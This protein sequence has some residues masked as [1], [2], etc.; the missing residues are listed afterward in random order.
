MTP[1][2][3]IKRKVKEVL[4]EFGLWHFFP[5]NNGL[6]RSGIPDIICIVNGQFVGIECK[7]DYSK[8]P[9]LLQIKCG[10][11]IKAAGGRWVLVRS[12]DDVLSL[13]T[14]LRLLITKQTRKEQ[15]AGN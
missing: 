6:G 9:T 2:G 4:K 15:H 12:E 7:A 11:E 1:E 5:G 14:Y 10:D 13:R 8:T 3:K